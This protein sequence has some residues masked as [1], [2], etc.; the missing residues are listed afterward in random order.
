MFRLKICGVR[1]KSDLDAVESSGGDAIGL[2]FFPPSVR[3]L[4]PD[5]A[6]TLELA[7]HAGKLELLKIGVFV[8]ETAKRLIEIDDALDLAAIQLHGDETVELARSLIAA[9]SRVV[10]A[11]KL[12]AG[13]LTKSQIQSTVAPWL[14][15]GAHPLLDADGGSQHGGTGQRLDW[16]TINDWA[17][18][19]MPMTWT[20]AG[21]LNP[22]NVGEAVEASG[23]TSVDVASGVE[24]P[25]GVKNAKL[26]KCFASEF[27][28]R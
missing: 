26:I 5:S 25:R 6:E 8:N 18:D 15:V 3:Y 7:K 4:D 20:L 16:A 19:M 14:D 11:I 13:K 12:P 9:G 24:N 27:F 21:G 22:D 17:A 23:A 10:R 2:N 28:Q 1:L